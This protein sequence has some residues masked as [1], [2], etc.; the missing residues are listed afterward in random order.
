MTTLPLPRSALVIGLTG[1]FASGKSEAAELFEGLGAIL[2]DADQLAREAALPGTKGFYQIRREFGENVVSPKGDLDRSALARLVFSDD[3]KRRT[4]EDLLHPEIRAL[5]LKRL[6]EIP[7]QKDNQR[8]VVLYV[9]PLLFESRIPYPEIEKTVT[10]SAP[11]HLCIA[12]ATL[13][14]HIT[15]EEAERR[16][17][18]QLPAEE[19]EKRADW[20]ILND[21]G[22][23][24]LQA[25]A[26]RIFAAIIKLRNCRSSRDK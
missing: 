2:I 12:R 18:A 1:S 5:F 14:D 10:V 13:R 17:N 25:E 7:C 9:A 24:H 4:L 21:H 22:L 11:K 19:K 8:T 15:P 23:E 26:A 3:S 20:I 6:A 16:Y